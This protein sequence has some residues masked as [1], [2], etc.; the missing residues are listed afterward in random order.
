MIF[1]YLAKALLPITILDLKFFGISILFGILGFIVIG[2]ATAIIM[3]CGILKPETIANNPVYLTA[4][5]TL[6]V[7]ISVIISLGYYYGVA[8]IFYNRIE[9][10]NNTQSA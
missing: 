5:C 1:K 7:Y 6:Y 9:K 2:I 8:H 3:I 4:F 10:Q